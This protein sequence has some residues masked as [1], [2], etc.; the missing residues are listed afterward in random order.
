VEEAINQL[1]I[2]IKASPKPKIF[3]SPN[4]KMPSRKRNAIPVHELS[5]RGRAKR[6]AASNTVARR[7]ETLDRVKK[8]RDDLQKILSDILNRLHEVPDIAGKCLV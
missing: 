1:H 7:A 5:P 3:K 4:I 8:Q 2:Q 6:V